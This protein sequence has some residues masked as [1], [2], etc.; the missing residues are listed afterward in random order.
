MAHWAITNLGS[1]ESREPT[2]RAR[3]LGEGL[4]AAMD[5]VGLDR[6]QTARRMGWSPTK[7]TRMLRGER[8]AKPEDVASILALCGVNGQER[9]RLLELCRDQHTK[10]WLQQ[11]G[12]RLPKQLHTLVDHEAQA[13]S[14]AAFEPVLVPGLL[15]TRDYARAVVRGIVNVPAAEV[16]ERVLARVARQE[17]LSRDRPV[18]SDFFMHEF[19][20]RLPVGGSPVMSEQLHHLL[21]MSVR[22]TVTLRVIPAA[23]GAHAAMA[24]GFWFMEFPTFRPVIYLE[25]ETSC[26]FLE[27][28]EEVAAYRKILSALADVALDEGQSRDLIAT[29][30]TELYA[31]REEDDE[32]P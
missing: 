26:L 20:L 5:K 9:T 13:K 16:D 7:V 6:K 29:M 8:G 15:Q 10:G 18:Q 21:Q 17:V 31:D 4:K 3:E 11:F 19:A 23:V 1:M 30:A 2:I 24:G 27:R 12:D 25:G 28:P 32:R 14:I 22:R